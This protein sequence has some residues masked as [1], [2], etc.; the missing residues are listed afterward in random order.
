MTASKIL[1]RFFSNR[2]KRLN[3]S[4]SGNFFILLVLCVFAVFSALPLL[5]TFSQA[6]KPLN[7]LFQYPPSL[8]PQH[9][10][11]TNFVSLFDLMSS[12]WVPFSRYVFN[13]AFVALVGTAGEIML[14]SMCAYPL[15]KMHLKG[16]EIIFW[17]IVTSLMFAPAVTDI[18]N[19]YTVTA[20]NLTDN[21]LS[22]ILPAC[23]SS[24][25]LYIMKQFMSQIPDA[26]IEAAK[27]DGA[28]N[29]KTL[30][31]IIM[32]NVKPAWLT[33]AIFAFQTLWVA[34]NSTYIYAEPMKSLPAALNQII[35]G[36]VAR[37]GAGAAA[38]VVL[39]VV[40]LVFFIFTQNQIIETMATSGMKE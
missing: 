40:P 27:I 1:R 26:L 5:L 19:Y 39:L 36:G 23:A 21:Y 16:G 12:T 37:A 22:I 4:K 10:T 20:L 9:P 2:T 35:T 11:L 25:G 31:V 30:W 33:L 29:F 18:I 38:G 32:P 13:T 17:L 15:A 28:G 3:R 6:L 14:G 24:L 7:E 8:L 34:P